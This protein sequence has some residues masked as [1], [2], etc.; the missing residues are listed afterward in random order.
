MTTRRVNL[1]RT[2]TERAQGFRDIKH[3]VAPVERVGY[4]LLRLGYHPEPASS[5]C[6][7]TSS[8]CLHPKSSDYRRGS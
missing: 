7:V 3:P 6:Q 1:D 8:N 4:Y 5:P 2:S